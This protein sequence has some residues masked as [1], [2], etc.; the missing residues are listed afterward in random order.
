ME[1]DED[2]AIS[3]EN[4]IADKDEKPEQQVLAEKT[5]DTFSSQE[6]A[7]NGDSENGLENQNEHRNENDEYSLEGTSDVTDAEFN[8]TVDSE[9]SWLYE[10]PQ[11][12]QTPG[13]K[14]QT[15]P[16][17]WLKENLTTPELM[18]VRGS[19]SAKLDVIKI[20]NRKGLNHTDP[21]IRGGEG[22]KKVSMQMVNSLDWDYDEEKDQ[23]NEYNKSR[24][25]SDD[26]TDNINDDFDPE[27]ELRLAYSKL[28]SDTERQ[29]WSEPASNNQK[30][31]S[32]DWSDGEDDLV[33]MKID[34]NSTPGNGVKPRSSLTDGALRRR[35]PGSTISQLATPRQTDSYE[36]DDIV[37]RP[38][39]GVKPRG[40]PQPQ[41]EEEIDSTDFNEDD[42]DDSAPVV[43]RG[44]MKRDSP[45]P[46][47]N[48][49]GLAKP[50]QRRQQNTATGI[51][52]RGSGGNLVKPRA[53][54]P[55]TTSD[56]GDNSLVAKISQGGD[57]AGI[58]RRAPG[59]SGGDVPAPR[60]SKESPQVAR[61]G[62]GIPQVR[63]STGSIPQRSG[64][65]GVRPR[66]SA[67]PSGI[68]RP[69]G[70]GAVS[71]SMQVNY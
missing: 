52:P 32:L 8:M 2:V 47:N 63:K 15:S 36:Y 53:V 39:S 67:S 6:N 46:R 10:S 64:E 33:P 55:K 66:G 31:F 71:Q 61:I 37:A 58:R 1:M 16:D 41:Y 50:V 56:I 7:K 48:S 49:S 26:F 45:S 44:A 59:D 11:K 54:M 29:A 62:G 24:L 69:R 17:K 20:E 68:A 51:K 65:G 18:R 22:Y 4:G 57:G 5:L 9:D 13:R 21:Q 60:K 12:L 14:I 19:L 28:N 70:S 23:S 30:P 3:R 40:A 27:E 34:F 38:T 25:Q 35:G 43:P 42:F